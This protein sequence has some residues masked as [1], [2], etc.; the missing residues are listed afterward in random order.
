MSLFGEFRVPS[1]AFALHQTF[2]TVPELVVEIERVVATE[3]VLTPYFWISGDDIATVERAL[4]SDPSVEN[5]HRLDEFEA[6]TLF[7]AEWTE[8]VET[9]VYAY[10]QIG[11]VILEA[12]GKVG[13]WVFRMRFDD[14]TQLDEFC[15]F[16]HEQEIPFQL[17]RLYELS[18]PRT[19]GQYGLTPKQQE[20]LVEAWEMGYFESPREA[21]LADVAETL[22]ITQQ[23]LSKRLQRGYNALV[24]NTLVV[25]SQSE[26]VN[27]RRIKRTE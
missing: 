19:G 7:R 1:E 6:T 22:G 26:R 3:N 12:S 27:D 15:D 20:A 21:S 8:N 5:L 23:S 14:R 10:T 17:V 11:A 16:C 4:A 18:H 13:E 25:T 9:I 24:S 2:R